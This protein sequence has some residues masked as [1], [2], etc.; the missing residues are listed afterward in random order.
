MGDRGAG[1][2]RVAVFDDLVEGGFCSE[3]SRSGGLLRATGE[4]LAGR[5]VG[6]K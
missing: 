1:L 5:R 4:W 6:S 3:Q 2:L